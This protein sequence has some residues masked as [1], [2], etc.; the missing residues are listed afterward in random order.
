MSQKPQ[1]TPTTD[2][3]INEGQIIPN[4]ILVNPKSFEIA[5]NPHHKP[6]ENSFKVVAERRVTFYVYAEL[7]E[8]GQGNRPVKNVVRVSKASRKYMTGI[9]NS[10]SRVYLGTFEQAVQI[11]CDHLYKL[12]T[13]GQRF[14]RVFISQLADTQ[15]AKADPDAFNY[16]LP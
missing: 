3:L 1:E 9:N 13:E 15:K 2:G 4:L 11:T 14:S 6:V 10:Y 7:L 8:P 12:V 5:V 16:S